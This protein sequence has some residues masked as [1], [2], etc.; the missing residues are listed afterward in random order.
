[1]E[2]II[3]LTFKFAFTLFTGPP[4]YVFWVRY[5]F[6]TFL[7][8]VFSGFSPHPYCYH[9]LS[10]IITPLSFLLLSDIILQVAS[11]WLHL[12]LHFPQPPF[13]PAGKFSGTYFH[14]NMSCLFR[15][16]FSYFLMHASLGCCC[17]YMMLVSNGCR[18][19]PFTFF[20]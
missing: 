19:G 9:L 10:F 6:L 1:L 2:N 7:F 5:A 12:K 3:D 15:C 4:F 13:A 17:N 20:N 18:L 14:I 8:R 16:R 11:L